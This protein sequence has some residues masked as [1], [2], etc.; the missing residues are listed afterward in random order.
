LRKRVIVIAAVAAAFANGS[1]V[2]VT[3]G[4]PFVYTAAPRYEP[5]AWLRGQERFPNGASVILVD[6]ANRRPLAPSF[7]ASADPAVSFDGARVLFS[8]KQ[9]SAAHW[10]IWEVPI[11]GGDARQLVRSDSDCVRPIYVPDGRIAY[12]RISAGSS[13]IEIA[14]PGGAP[15]RLTF[16][17]GRYLTSDVLRDGRILFENDGEIFTVYP[18]GTGVESLRCDHGPR[19]AN[20]RQLASG[21]VV[22]SNAG[23]LARFT[24]ALTSEITVAQPDGE[25]AGPVAELAPGQ[26]IV[27]LRK[28]DGVFRLALWNEQEGRTSPIETPDRLNAIQPA[29]VHLRVPP[30]QFPS[31]LVETRKTGNLLCLDARNGAAVKTVQMYTRDEAGGSVLLGRQDLAADG[32]FYVEVPADRPLRIEML[33]GAGRAVRSEHGWFWMRPSE[34]RICVG[35]HTGPERSPENK[36]PEVLLRSIIP[37]KLLGQKK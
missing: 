14:E 4:I 3:P 32:S 9:T 10:Q 19:R 37:E 27:S 36:V 7:F 21:D 20:A 35:C 24:S 15:Q 12:T 28:P 6:G 34:Q 22:F 31:A 11:A 16:A 5:A 33:D 2:T 18:D 29:A 8:A 25:A 13:D 23:R 17:P 30:K 26:W 1:T